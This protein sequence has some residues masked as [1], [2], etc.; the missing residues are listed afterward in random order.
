MT[1]EV[2]SNGKKDHQFGFRHEYETLLVK[3]CDQPWN[4]HSLDPA[5]NHLGMDVLEL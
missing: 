4:W 2:A 5:K 1:F 3:E